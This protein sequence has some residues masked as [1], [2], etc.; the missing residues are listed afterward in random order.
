MDSP[1]INGELNDS[2][3][4]SSNK[5]HDEFF[6]IWMDV[7][8]NMWIFYRP[9]NWDQAARTRSFWRPENWCGMEKSYGNQRVQY[10]KQHHE[11]KEKHGRWI[12]FNNQ[13]SDFNIFFHIWPRQALT[14]ADSWC[15]ARS[16]LRKSKKFVVR[17]PWLSRLYRACTSSCWPLSKWD[18]PP[19]NQIQCF[20][21]RGVSDI[22]D[23]RYSGRF[24]AVVVACYF[25]L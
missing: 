22:S 14:C 5:P 15:Y 17:M 24:L 2:H 10:E 1:A 16:E 8:Q 25:L 18:D 21:K 13:S 7:T 23:I 3:L 6:G 19:F 12:I 9:K 11:I 4:E 20:Y